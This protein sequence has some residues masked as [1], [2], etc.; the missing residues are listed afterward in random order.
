MN[1]DQRDYSRRTQLAS[2][3]TFL[4]WWRTGL[5]ALAAALAAGQVVPSLDDGGER[6]PF[7]VIGVAL[8]GL[9]ILCFA[10]GHVRRVRLERALREGGYAEAD[11][12]V[13][14]FVAGAAVV[15]GLLVVAA[16]VVDP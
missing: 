8:G 6:W 13:M 1:L 15:V 14:A 7:A 9:G 4:A 5:T 12:A 3:R 16:I 2:E 10:Y 11:E